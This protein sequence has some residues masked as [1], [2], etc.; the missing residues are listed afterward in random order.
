MKKSK[1]IIGLFLICLYLPTLASLI[2]PD[3]VFSKK[4][5]RYLAQKP[6]LS[7]DTLFSGEFGAD[8][9]AYLNDQFPFRESIASLHTNCERVLGKSEISGV[10]FGASDYFIE[11]HQKKDYTTNLAKKN[12]TAV[13][14]FLKDMSEQLGKDN[15]RFLP[16]PSA[17]T[18]LTGYLPK[19]APP[20]AE[21]DVL[22]NYDCKELLVPVKDALEEIPSEEASPIYYRTDH[23]W[24]MYGAFAGYEAWAKSVGIT[25]YLLNDFDISNI[26]DD[27]YGSISARVNTE[28]KPD[29]LLKFTPKFPVTYQVEYLGDDKRYDS[30]YAMEM[31]ASP[32]PYAV[33]LKGNQAFTRIRTAGTDEEM[34]GRK[35]LVIK[36]SFGNSL[37]PF[38]ANHYSET[39]VVD[40]RYYNS[41][42]SEFIKTEKVTDI[43]VA[44]NLAQMAKER[45]LYRIT[46]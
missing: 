12:E 20:S 3:D 17:E 21:N 11:H 7:M 16:I 10:Y 36:D 26:K 22:A 46:K 44:F 33:Y 28:V 4:E 1:I 38:L 35:L 32:E 25:P 30:L 9:E 5:K 19:G 43:C 24:T 14:T 8:Y 13:F 2:K 41:S 37:V 45:T 27:F 40:L 18:V 39:L 42:L 15:V 31:L 6:K 29:I 34:S 23:H